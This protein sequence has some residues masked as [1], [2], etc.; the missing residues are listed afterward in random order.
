MGFML[1][2]NLSVAQFFSVSPIIIASAG[3]EV[4]PDKQKDRQTKILNC[5][6]VFSCRVNNYMH[7]KI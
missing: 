1:L 4:S 2:H 7:L 6:F 3:P 5:L